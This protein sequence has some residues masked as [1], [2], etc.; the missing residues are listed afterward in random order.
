MVL[1]S[2][3]AVQLLLAQLQLSSAARF[4]P[5]EFTIEPA[6]FA[7][8][9][10][11]QIGAAQVNGSSTVVSSAP[12]QLSGAV[13]SNRARNARQLSL[14]NPAQFSLALP[15]STTVHLRSAQ[16]QLN[17]SGESDRARP[18]VGQLT[19]VQLLSAQL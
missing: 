12:A 16:L 17:N 2:S 6:Q 19:A 1:L 8:V 14:L 18:G 10:L 13:Q 4:N 3:A 9:N 15:S 7:Q 11:V 5:T